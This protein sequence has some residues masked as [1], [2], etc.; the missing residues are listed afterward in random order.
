MNRLP[1][2]ILFIFFTL[3]TILQASSTGK[4]AGRI[5]DKN[6]GEPLITANVLIKDFQMGDAT[7]LD[8]Y[9]LIL[10]VPPGEYTLVVMYI[11]YRTVEV[12]EVNVSID[13]TT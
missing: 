11:G 8:G 1:A 3:F 6:S 13:L 9:Y 5:T 12:S 7:D 2:F 10:N 4:I